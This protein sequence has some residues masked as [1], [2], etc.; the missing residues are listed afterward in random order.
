MAGT[1][2]AQVKN[3]ISIGGTKYAY[4]GTLVPDTSYATNGDTIAAPAAPA[5]TLPEKIDY[6][7][8]V[9]ASGLVARYNGETSKV[10]IFETGSASGEPLKEAAN[11]ANFSTSTFQFECVGC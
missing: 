10:Q 3:R 5:L 4:Y 8:I 6:F 7:N 11:A 9:G 1:I 2:T